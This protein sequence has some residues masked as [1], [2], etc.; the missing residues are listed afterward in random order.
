MD[1]LGGAVGDAGDVAEPQPGEL[2]PLVE[3][4][5]PRAPLG[6]LGGLGA[7]ALG[8]AA[9]ALG[10]QLELGGDALLDRRLRAVARLPGLREQRQPRAARD[11]SPRSAAR[12]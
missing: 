4:G 10:Q 9:V 11:R 8:A 2:E 12:A 3:R 6:A 1:E 5:H 7:L